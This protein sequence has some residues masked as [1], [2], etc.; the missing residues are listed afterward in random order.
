MGKQELLCLLLI[1]NCMTIAFIKARDVLPVC[2]NAELMGCMQTGIGK[3]PL[4][5]N[6]TLLQGST[7]KR[8]R[9]IVPNHT[10]KADLGPKSG[11]IG[12]NI[13]GPTRKALFR[14][15]AHDGDRA[16]S[17]QTSSLPFKITVE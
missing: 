14:G 16:I 6:A 4:V 15:F 1:G 8:P 10:E 11:N 12:S 13:G 17:T 5:V 3:Q 2:Q 7:Q 9:H